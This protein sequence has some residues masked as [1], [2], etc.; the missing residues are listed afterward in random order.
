MPGSAPSGPIDRA[1]V[2]AANLSA[3]ELL[4]AELAASL[5][6]DD[7]VEPAAAPQGAPLSETDAPVDAAPLAKV[8]RSADPLP[9]EWKIPGLKGD[10]KDG[11]FT[12]A[13]SEPVPAP[14]T[15]AVNSPPEEASKAESPERSTPRGT[16]RKATDADLP[17]SR[18]DTEEVVIEQ[19]VVVSDD[20]DEAELKTLHEA[21]KLPPLKMMGDNVVEQEDMV[22]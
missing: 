5:N 10:W 20:E 22:K 7:N 8:N 21:F 6:A 14:T 4:K 12:A 19:A 17:E 11:A 2:L 9:S 3:A 15:P 13:A 16:K 18:L 1:A